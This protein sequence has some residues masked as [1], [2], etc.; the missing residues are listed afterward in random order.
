MMR[1]RRRGSERRATR[2]ATPEPR[3]S[4]TLMH[5]AQ[6]PLDAMASGALTI[7][8]S[9]RTCHVCGMRKQC[10]KRCVRRER[11]TEWTCANCVFEIYLRHEG[12]QKSLTLCLSRHCPPHCAPVLHSQF[13]TAHV[14]SLLVLGVPV[15]AL[16]RRPARNSLATAHMVRLCAYFIC[17]L[18]ICAH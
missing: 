5:G 17:F 15:V 12:R 18:S 1:C 8:L 3:N 16:F 14:R 7:Q 9:D 6:I 2:P 13:D 11:A 4:K 10:L